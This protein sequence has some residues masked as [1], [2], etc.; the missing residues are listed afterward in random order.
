MAK[1]SN[2]RQPDRAPNPK[3]QAS[4]TVQSTMSTA[5]DGPD[6]GRVALRA[7]QRYMERGRSDGGDL[8]DWLTAEGELRP[9]RNSN[10]G[11]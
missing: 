11:E 4:S 9:D 1:S 10:R 3:S 2:G 7:Y 5:A 6:H 8:D